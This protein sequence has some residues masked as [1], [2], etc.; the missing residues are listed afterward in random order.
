MNVNSFKYSQYQIISYT[1]TE[2]EKVWRH[3]SDLHCGIRGKL[4]KVI[5]GTETIVAAAY[6]GWLLNV[7]LWSF[8]RTNHYFN[9]LW[10]YKL[11]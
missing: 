1:V 4:G 10:Y 11:F 2:C 5:C 9:Q 3:N 8:I 7:S 6:I